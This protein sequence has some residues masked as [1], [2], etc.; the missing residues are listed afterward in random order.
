MINRL[1]QPAPA[2]ISNDTKD[3][4]KVNIEDA[5]DTLQALEN[6][7]S[8]LGMPLSPEEDRRILRRIDIWYSYLP[9]YPPQESRFETDS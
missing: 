7:Q 8:Q 3:I 2:V 9:C 4:S 6:Y 1:D 5:D